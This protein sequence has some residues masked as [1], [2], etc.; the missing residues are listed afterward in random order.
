MH[1]QELA[2]S[3]GILFFKIAQMR[4]GAA[5]PEAQGEDKQRVQ[6]VR[7]PLKDTRAG[8]GEER[9]SL[10]PFPSWI[11][12]VCIRRQQRRWAVWSGQTEKAAE[13]RKMTVHSVFWLRSPL[14]P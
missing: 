5:D 14:V 7:D 10:V 2:K 9:T 13:T 11:P 12:L 1:T 8:A 4:Q 3:Y 6:E